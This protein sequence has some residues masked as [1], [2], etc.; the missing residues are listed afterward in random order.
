MACNSIQLANIARDCEANV[1]G[2]KKVWLTNYEADMFKLD[3]TTGD[4]ANQI[5]GVTSGKTW[6]T[7]EFRKG[8][9]SLTSNLN[10]DEAAGTNFIQ[11]DLLLQFSR[12]ETA[13]RT[14]IAALSIGEVCGI[15]LDCNGKYWAI[16]FDEPVTASAGVGQTGVARTDSNNYQI[17][18]TDISKSYPYEVLSSVV[19]GLQSGD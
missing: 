13:K 4:T 11:S 2:I 17:T 8:T 14:A 5:T 6:Y 3:G 7:Y 19:S 1:G 16:G 12:M 15:V 9:G 10:V 18:L